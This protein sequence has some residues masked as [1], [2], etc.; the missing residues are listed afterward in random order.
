MFFKSMLG[1]V[2]GLVV[3]AMLSSSVSM[4]YMESEEL[5]EV[6]PREVVVS[7]NDVFVPG[8]LKST[9][10]AFVLLSGLFPNGCYNWDRAEVTVDQHGKLVSITP[11]AQV[12][13]GMCIQVLVPFTREV[14]LGSLS[15]GSYRVRV[16]AGDGTFQEKTLNI[17]GVN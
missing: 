2:S 11:Y 16:S 9:D 12:N 8:G 6:P 1:K 4:A 5:G 7:V 13:Q 14:V 15:A 3:V 17:E 10:R